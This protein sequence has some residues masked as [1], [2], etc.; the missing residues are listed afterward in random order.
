MFI[1]IKSHLNKD[2][3]TSKIACN[4]SIYSDTNTNLENEK[5]GKNINSKLLGLAEKLHDSDYNNISDRNNL[6]SLNVFSK[7]LDH[8][9]SN[10]ANR[11][12]DEMRKNILNCFGENKEVE[13]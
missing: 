9:P 11:K 6:N 13:K 5:S 1:S 2:K 12:V 3:V 10:F 8:S 4:K 7:E